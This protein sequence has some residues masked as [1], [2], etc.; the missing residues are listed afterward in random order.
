M[1]ETHI[2]ND[3]ACH[4]FTRAFVWTGYN[5]HEVLAVLDELDP[6]AL[7]RLQFTTS[8]ATGGSELR[9]W[10]S[11]KMGRVI[12]RYVWVM[13]SSRCMETDDPKVEI[14]NVPQ[15]TEGGWLLRNG[16]RSFG[17]LNASLASFS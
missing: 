5:Q 15:I 10:P 2:S 16:G 8:L 9:W 4:C 11:T 17:V 7:Q 14:T 1:I 13:V 3:K 6:K 12:P